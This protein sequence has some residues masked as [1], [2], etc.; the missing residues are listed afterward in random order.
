MGTCPSGSLLCSPDEIA[1]TDAA[2]GTFRQLLG[3]M[4][5]RITTHAYRDGGLICE[6]RTSP[7]RPRM[8]RIAPDGGLLP[9]SSYNFARGGFVSVPAPFEAISL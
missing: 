3:A 4:A 2:I 8:W 7:A 1:I 5:G 9:D 6:V